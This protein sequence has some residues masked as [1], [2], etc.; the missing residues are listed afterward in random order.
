M[1]G[2]PL[3]RRN[4]WGGRLSAASEFADQEQLA[5]ML[6][7]HLDPE[8]T[9]WTSL[10]CKPRSRVSG[11]GYRKRNIRAGIPDVMVVF[12]GRL[13]FIELKSKSGIAS[14]A[15]REVRAELLKSGAGTF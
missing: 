14:K 2:L 10:E 15:Q 4:N 1:W 6:W 5:E 12:R 11:L 8:T 7:R 3:K 9:W 13:I